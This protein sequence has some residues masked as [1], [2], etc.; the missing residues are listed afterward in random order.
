MWEGVGKE[1]ERERERE[2]NKV[3]LKNIFVANTFI[4]QINT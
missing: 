3:H 2:R 4:S 1:R